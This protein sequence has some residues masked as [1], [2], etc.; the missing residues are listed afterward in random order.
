MWNMA[1]WSVID[2]HKNALDMIC[3]NIKIIGPY[4]IN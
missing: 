1:Q 2:V 4:M 3:V